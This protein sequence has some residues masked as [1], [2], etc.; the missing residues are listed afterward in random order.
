VIAHVGGPRAAD[1]LRRHGQARCPQDRPVEQ[2][3]AMAKGQKRSN[4]ELKKPKAKK[5]AGTP[6]T[7]SVPARGLVNPPSV[8]KKKT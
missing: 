6:A 2:E 8:P 3:A 5:P 7:A 1:S 4:R